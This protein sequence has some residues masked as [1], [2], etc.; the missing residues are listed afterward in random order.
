MLEYRKG[1]LGVSLLLSIE[2]S[3]LPRALVPACLMTGLAAAAGAAWADLR[4]RSADALGDGVFLHPYPLQIFLMVFGFLLVFRTSFS[5]HRYSEC[6][7]HVATMGSKWADAVT[8]VAA[9]GFANSLSGPDRLAHHCFLLRFL[10][11]CSCMHALALQALRE[12]DDLGNLESA[13]SGAEALRAAAADRAR[14]G[15]PKYRVERAYTSL[16]T[17]MGISYYDEGRQRA[18]LAR[19]RLPVIGLKGGGETMAD[20]GALSATRS[21]RVLVLMTALQIQ[22]E[23]ARAGAQLSG[24]GPIDTRVYHV[25]SDG[26]AGFSQA[27]KIVLTPFPFPYSQL[28]GTSCGPASGR[29][30]ARPVRG[31]DGAHRTALFVSSRAAGGLLGVHADR[32]GGVHPA[33]ADA[34]RDVLH[35]RA[36]VLEPARG[37]AG[38]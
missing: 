26:F 7:S 38:D 32:D 18:A 9:F 28:T 13:A 6:R 33:P 23:R 25:L 35:G 5:Y 10:H 4:R 22:L 16:A 20:G 19:A 30:L 2:G 15:G 1:F 37:G 8:F 36:D 27:L 24:S 12:D 34:L 31:T 21:E 3:A 14:G 29:R 11:R 17:L